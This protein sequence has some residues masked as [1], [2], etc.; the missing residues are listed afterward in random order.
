MPQLDAVSTVPNKNLRASD[1]LECKPIG[2]C[3]DTPVASAPAMFGRDE[4]WVSAFPVKKGGGRKIEGGKTD[5]HCLRPVDSSLG[6]LQFQLA[7]G[8]PSC[9]QPA[10][11]LKEMRLHI[12][13]R[14][15]RGI[16]LAQ[17]TL[18]KSRSST[19]RYLIHCSC[20]N[21]HVVTDSQA[22]AQ[23][24]CGCGQQ[25][26]VPPLSALAEHH[27]EAP[28]LALSKEKNVPAQHDE[29]SAATIEPKSS[30][31]LAPP[32]RPEDAVIF[33]M[34]I[35]YLIFICI[36]LIVPLAVDD[37]KDPLNW[38]C[39]S[40]IALGVV[41]MVSLW[42]GGN[43]AF[44]FANRSQRVG[45][46]LG[47]VIGLAGILFVGFSEPSAGVHPDLTQRRA[48]H[49]NRCRRCECDVLRLLG[50]IVGWLFGA[51]QT[52]PSSWSGAD[53]R[54]ELSWVQSGRRDQ[55]PGLET[56]L[57]I[58]RATTSRLALRQHC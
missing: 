34:C 44:D 5:G 48:G 1:L 53:H 14:P 12:I 24:L 32:L 26:T 22:G 39:L 10:T 36:G 45:R 47:I 28:H 57:L 4:H 29:S 35:G 2:R 56:A 46:N 11:R 50:R 8:A 17:C 31:K 42:K 6:A 43:H 23:I 54:G 13:F 16:A 49:D 20:S 41:G 9:R 27:L 18:V 38:V 51:W 33:F 30:D 40:L 7:S 52:G 19:M 3:N 21:A 15:G 37:M 25:I 58:G 55:P